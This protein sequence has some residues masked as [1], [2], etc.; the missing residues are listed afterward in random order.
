MCR[1]MKESVFA[2]PLLRAPPC[3]GRGTGRAVSGSSLTVAHASAFETTA[4]A[5][6][7]WLGLGLGLGLGSRLGG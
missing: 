5:G 3:L 1:C 2:I 4:L 6:R 7:T